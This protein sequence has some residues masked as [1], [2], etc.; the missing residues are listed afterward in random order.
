MIAVKKAKVLSNSHLQ[1]N[2]Y[3]IKI[4]AP[5]VAERAWPGQ[6][7]MVRCSPDLSVH[8]PLLPRPFSLA[9]AGNG[10]AEI[11]YAVVGKG[12]ALLSKVKPG[13]ELDLLGPLGNG[14][15]QVGGWRA[16]GKKLVLV[17]GGY[18]AAPLY[19]LAERES[20]NDKIFLNFAE[21]SDS[22]ITAD[23]WDVG[24]TEMSYY[25][26]DGSAGR[27]GILT[28]EILN[29]YVFPSHKNQNRIVY[30]CGPSGLLKSVAKWANKGGVECYVSME[31]RMACG[32][33]AC[34]GCAIKVGGWYKR[35]CKEG[36]VFRASEVDWEG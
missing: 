17:A 31:E 36:P 30:A 3:K 25:T 32:V 15:P 27:R 22:L 16:T 6:F 7:V 24:K 11:I 10:C 33:G 21:N 5:D 8:D 20:A 13:E 9:R 35:V 2:Y 29:S 23:L 19:W 12:T 34:Y 18:G 1:A 28:E 4:E 14:F 26:E